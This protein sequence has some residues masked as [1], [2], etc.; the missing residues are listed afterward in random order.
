MTSIP[1]L[2]VDNLSVEFRTRNGIVTA[3][4]DVS[5]HVEKGEV[6]GIVGE[7]GSGKSVTA[8]TV[9]GLLDSAGYASNGNASYDGI[10]LTGADEST[11]YP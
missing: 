11:L 9:M 8:Y 6:L 7:S 2:S 10:P 1:I 3:L 5:L 4:E